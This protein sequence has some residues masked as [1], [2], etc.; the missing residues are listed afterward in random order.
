M[1]P[2]I[3][4]ELRTFVLRHPRLHR[5]A[6]WGK[7]QLQG[8]PRPPAAAAHL[9]ED[10]LKA[11]FTAAAIAELDQFFLSGARINFAVQ[12]SP[13]ISV[14]LVLYNRA[15][16]TL[17]CLLSLLTQTELPIE[18]VAVDNCSNDATAELFTRVR[19]VRYIRNRENAH[20]LK[21]ANQGAAAA[22][23][24]SLLFLNN[25]TRVA[26]GAL[27]AAA[28]V[29]QD[30]TV[31]AVGARLVLPNGTLQEAGSI[32]W[33]D[34]TCLGYGRGANPNE[35]PYMFRRDVDYCSGAFLLTPSALFRELGGFDEA[36][37]PAYYEEVD[38][39]LRLWERGKRVVYEPRALVHHFE[40]ASSSH[41]ERALQMQRERR[42]I[43]ET[44]RA[45][46]LSTRRAPAPHA[47]LAARVQSERRRLLYI[48]ERLPHPFYGAG[49][50][51]ANRIVQAA[52]QL[53]WEV[54]VLPA[55]YVDEQE[56]WSRIYSTLPAEV[57]VLALP[58]WG[59]AGAARAIR[60]RA[61]HYDAIFV[62]R[63]T[64]MRELRAV[65][66]DER[67]E[68]A[69][70]YDAEAIFALRDQA[71]AALIG[72]PLDAGEVSRRIAAELELARGVNLISAVSERE[73]Q[74]FR[75]C[76][77]NAV[78]VLGHCAEIVRNSAPFSSRRGYLMA[79]AFHDDTGPNSDAVF[80]FVEKVLPHILEKQPDALF[81][82]AG[83]NRSPRLTALRHP[84]V[85]VLGQV[86]S[87]L[88]LYESARVFVAPTRFS[89]GI[90]LKVVEAAA[91]GLPAVVTELLLE[92]LGW[93]SERELLAASDPVKFAEHCLALHNDEQLW[94][95]RQQAALDR[96]ST[97]YSPQVFAGRVE[98]LLNAAL[99]MR[100]GSNG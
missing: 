59:P 95:H 11:Q 78:H 44:R 57:E 46:Y 90:P 30:P 99:A 5:L 60:E 72:K 4:A 42:S 58:P 82:V 6:R 94:S 66:C 13:Q 93:S 12:K 50:P 24:S 85:R 73:A 89:A 10:A 86:E 31:G 1:N 17:Q 81:T 32:A 56:S 61:G 100:H 55:I 26:P 28:N 96:L 65:L 98:A 91:A 23:G 52:H 68:P 97:E 69:L 49:Y 7:R 71:Y 20:F 2:R 63:P 51:R 39:C 14:I 75:E 62:S 47:V 9:P 16:L 48:D 21:G 92:Q 77:F 84:A 25:D 19:G 40:F 34:G 15:E 54:T 88:P 8:G 80:W 43:F 35:A 36:Y 70:I 79:G 83:L 29:L 37:A 41:S 33:N 27:A 87:L 18:I 67:R 38:Y 64:T 45:G 22:A 3:S 74:R 53:G 76:G